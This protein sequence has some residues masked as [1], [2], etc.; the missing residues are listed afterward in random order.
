MT[1]PGRWLCGT[2]RRRSCRDRSIP[3]HKRQPGG[4][5]L[6]PTTPRLVQ[7]KGSTMDPQ[8]LADD[9]TTPDAERDEAW[10]ARVGISTP[11]EEADL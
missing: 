4:V 6:D 8:N 11:D 2:E 1:R 7:Q 10:L 5:C 3:A 9:Q